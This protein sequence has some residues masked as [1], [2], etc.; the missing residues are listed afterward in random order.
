MFP[1]NLVSTGIAEFKAQQR[2]LVS[3]AVWFLQTLLLSWFSSKWRGLVSPAYWCLQTLFLSWCSVKGIGVSWKL[4]PANI[5]T[6][7]VH[8][9]EISFSNRLVLAS[10]VIVGW[11][12]QDF[13]KKFCGFLPF[14]FPR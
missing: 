10:I 11:C 12:L 1:V 14:G 13:I 5:I 8:S 4:V 9:K 6:K 3:P 7:L 2:G